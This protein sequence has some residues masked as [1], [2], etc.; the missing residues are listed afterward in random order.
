MKKLLL[1]H[2]LFYRD[3]KPQTDRQRHQYPQHSA[4]KET[5]SHFNFCHHL[6]NHFPHCKASPILFSLQP[7][8]AFLP[9]LFF[10]TLSQSPKLFLPNLFSIPT[11]TKGPF[12]LHIQFQVFQPL[13]HLNSFSRSSHSHCLW[14]CY[15]VN[16]LAP[17][18]S[19]LCFH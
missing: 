14:S 3:K 11:V 12:H 8:H 10:P 15:S 1:E 16:I 19:F 9:L 4:L 2:K 5:H 18:L 17:N 13:Q 7:H 6:H